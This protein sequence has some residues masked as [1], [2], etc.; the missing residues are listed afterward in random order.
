MEHTEAEVSNALRDMTLK[1]TEPWTYLRLSLK[2]RKNKS[3][4][5]RFA[6]V[7]KPS[8]IDYLNRVI[9]IFEE[10][11]AACEIRKESEIRSDI[12]YVQERVEELKSKTY[13]GSGNSFESND[14]IQSNDL[15]EDQASFWAQ[16][17]EKNLIDKLTTL[18]IP[19]LEEEWKRTNTP[20]NEAAIGY[21]FELLKFITTRTHRTQPHDR[22][23]ERLFH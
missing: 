14:W 23:L 4:L 17:A 22:W 5:E 20:R 3:R 12:R 1:S 8:S 6:N 15:D 18:Y 2:L 9:R 10:E 21:M 13:P 16:G 11:I 19:I 7:L